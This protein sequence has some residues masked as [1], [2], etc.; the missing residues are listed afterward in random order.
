[1][2]L[3]FVA[4]FL[5][6]A[7]PAFPVFAGENSAKQQAEFVSNFL[8]FV[9]WPRGAFLDEKAPAIVCV[10]GDAPVAAA[11]QKDAARKKGMTHEPVIKV[12]SSTE[13]TPACHILFVSSKEMARWDAIQKTFGMSSVF[14]VGDAPGFS[15]KGGIVEFFEQGGHTKLKINLKMATKARFKISS[16]LLKIAEI[17]EQ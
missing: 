14:T 12:L 1:M 3:A 11:L 16:R 2:S 15:S 10:L 9:E 6:A 13:L 7:L 5:L 8:S 4:G 17:V